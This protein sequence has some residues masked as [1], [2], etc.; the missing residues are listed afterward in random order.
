MPKKRISKGAR[1]KGP[2]PEQIRRRKL[3]IGILVVAAVV[4]AVTIVVGTLRGS[5][6]LSQAS[7]NSHRV[8]L[9]TDRGQI[10]MEVYPDLMPAT[11]AN[12]DKLVQSG[13]Y[14][15]LKFHRVED[16]VIQ[17]GDPIGNGTGG[18]GWKIRL[19]TNPQLPN[20]RGAVGMARAMDPDSAGSQFYILKQDAPSLDGGYAVFGKVVQGMDVVDQ[21]QIGDKMLSVK[22]V[23]E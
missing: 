8:T 12:F 10:V 22:E 19:E 6:E 13:F 9:D 4:L 14:N 20:V 11:V 1:L 5:Q 21:I 16:W 23:Q 3:F 17:G 2:S 15:G 7:E 18:P